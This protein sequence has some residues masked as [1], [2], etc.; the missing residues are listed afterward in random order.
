MSGNNSSVYNRRQ[1]NQ[2]TNGSVH[3]RGIPRSLRERSDVLLQRALE[4]SLR[5]ATLNRLPSSHT[6]LD[7]MNNQNNALHQ[8][9][10]VQHNHNI[11]F[12]ATNEVNS[13]KI[14]N[15]NGVLVDEYFNEMDDYQR[16]IQESLLAQ[17][18]K[19]TEFSLEDAQEIS[20]KEYE[21]NQQIHDEIYKQ[22]GLLR[23]I[24]FKLN[25]VNPYDPI[26]AEFF[27]ESED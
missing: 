15:S 13:N 26:F 8:V 4:L 9:D 17:N 1:R 10:N 21:I 25:G 7:N 11:H 23:S 14:E 6:A 27:N 3:F 20:R 19:P 12:T 16:A 22:K 2:Q 5:E 24:L 18:S